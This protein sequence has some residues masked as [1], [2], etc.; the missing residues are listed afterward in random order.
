MIAKVGP[1][2]HCSNKSHKG[3]KTRHFT[4]MTILDKNGWDTLP[5]C[6]QILDPLLDCSRLIFRKQHF[7]FLSN[8]LRSPTKGYVRLALVMQQNLFLLELSHLLLRLARFVLEMKRQDTAS[9]TTP[10][11]VCAV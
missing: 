8:T 9:G 10:D 3:L 1:Q 5:S 7:P 2:E 6:S 4:V 11:T